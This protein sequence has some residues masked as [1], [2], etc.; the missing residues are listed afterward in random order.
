MNVKMSREELLDRVWIQ[1]FYVHEETFH[2]SNPSQGNHGD[3]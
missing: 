3:H 2:I 1:Y